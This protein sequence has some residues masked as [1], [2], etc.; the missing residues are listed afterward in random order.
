MAL[1]SVEEAL[2]RILDGVEP[3]PAE[4]VPIAAAAGRTLAAPLAARLTQP[5]FDASAM[6]GYAVRH[7]DVRTL[8]ATLTEI[9]QAAAGHPFAGSV[10]PGQAVRIFTGAPVPAGADAVVIQENVARDGANIIV[11]DGVA[12]R[13]NIRA[14]GFDFRVGDTLLEAGRRIGPRELSL[15]AAMGYG[16]LPVRRRPRVAVLATGDELVQPGGSLGPGQIIASNHLGVAALAEASG[17]EARLLGI[18]RDTRESLDAHIAKAGDA[19]VLITI[20]G[21]SVGDHDLVA[22]VLEARGM[23][24]A[25]W[26]IALRPGK[27]LMFGRLGDARVLGLPGNPVSAIVCARVFLVPLIHALL[28]RPD[29]GQGLQAGPHRRGPGGQRPAHALHA[30]DLKAR[31]RWSV[32]RSPRCARRTAPSWPLWRSPTACWCA[33]STRPRRRPAAP[34]RSCRSTSDPAAAR[35]ATQ[36]PCGT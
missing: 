34:C 28:G 14:Q 22:P 21:A 25:F 3:T 11:R 23:A 13:G 5:P 7:A 27:P 31:R 15:A 2:Q 24:L 19:D 32:P 36:T 17:A 6:D 9:G 29:Q 26:K 20:G 1:L 10:G 16:E 35:V 30:G 33:P 18:A 8:P 4:S 12:E